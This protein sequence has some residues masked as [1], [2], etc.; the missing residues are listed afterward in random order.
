MDHAAKNTPTHPA[1]STVFARNVIYELSP[2]RQHKVN[3]ITLSTIN[4]MMVECFEK[5]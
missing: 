3:K 2:R 1:W 5:L 4:E